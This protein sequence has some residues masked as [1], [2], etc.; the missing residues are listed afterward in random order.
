MVA[1]P[2]LPFTP[3]AG[4][5]GSVITEVPWKA[6]YGKDFGKSLYRATLDISKNHLAGYLFIKK[7]SDSSYRILFN[8]DFGMQFL[9]LEFSGRDFIVHYVFPSMDKKSLMKL[10]ETDFRM[11]IFPNDDIGK[12]M[13]QEKSGTGKEAYI[14]KMKSGKWLYEVSSES[15]EILSIASKGKMVSKT[16]LELDSNRG[17]Q[18]TIRISNPFIKLKLILIPMD[19]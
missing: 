18:R 15:K 6:L 4:E 12:L 10:L 13:K 1:G 7:T 5:K 17:L 3:E 8:N 16:L 11:L 2:A 9:D 19:K 14:V